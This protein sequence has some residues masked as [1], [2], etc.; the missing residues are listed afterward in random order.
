[1]SKEGIEIRS[2]NNLQIFNE[3]FWVNHGIMEVHN[4]MNKLK[5]YNIEFPRSDKII[6]GTANQL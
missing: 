1:M 3:I 4:P 5:N 2:S 6:K